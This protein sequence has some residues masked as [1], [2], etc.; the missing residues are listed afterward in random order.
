MSVEYTILGVLMDEPTH[1][2]SIKK[3]LLGTVSKSLGLNDGQLYPALA[4]LEGKGWI[5]KQVV[6]QPRSPTKHLYRVTR[7]G[8][9]ALFAWLQTADPGGEP[10]AYDFFWRDDFLRKCSFFRYLPAE[11]VASQA[12]GKL[13]EVDA[14]IAELEE[15]LARM[16]K[17]QSDPYRRMIVDYGIRYQRMRRTWI[18]DL[19]ARALEARLEERPLPGHARVAS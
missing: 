4:R 17:G 19:L 5:E 8:E 15:F 18:G 13:E 14:R 2:Y 6:P 1:G 9:A 11:T 10:A 7:E 3:H 16:E 12:R